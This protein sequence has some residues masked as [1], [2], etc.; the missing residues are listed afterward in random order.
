ML[1][2]AIG[3]QRRARTRGCNSAQGKSR[4]RDRL[5]ARWIDELDDSNKRLDAL[6]RLENLGKLALPSLMERIHWQKHAPLLDLL[7]CSNPDA[8]QIGAIYGWLLTTTPSS[9]RLL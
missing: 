1:S 9:P 2:L 4:G 3:R 6:R 8:D 5:V 7:D